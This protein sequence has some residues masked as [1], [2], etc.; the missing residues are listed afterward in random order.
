MDRDLLV[1]EVKALIV[2]AVNLHHF[3]IDSI[4]ES[5]TLGAGGLNLDSID[6]LEIVVTIEKH[7]G[8][9]VSDMAKGQ[10]YFRNIGSI[11]DFVLQQ[12]SQ[13]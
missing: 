9:K 13:A 7:F 6:A 12:K 2:K 8:V 4:Q 1:A 3:P 10:E 11:T 5:T